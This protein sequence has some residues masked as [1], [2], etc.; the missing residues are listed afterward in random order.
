VVT[1]SPKH[2]KYRF[3][4]HPES[5]LSPVSVANHEPILFEAMGLSDQI[6]VG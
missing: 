5:P 2:F 3:Q 4:G 1:L 6:M